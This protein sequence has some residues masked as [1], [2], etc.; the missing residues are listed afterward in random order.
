MGIGFQT[1]VIVPRLD[2]LAGCSVIRS[3]LGE[4]QE[5]KRDLTGET[6]E[7]LKI[8]TYKHACS[9]KASHREM[10]KPV[11]FDDICDMIHLEY[12]P[13]SLMKRIMHM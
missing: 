3:R 12:C 8:D 2:V 7:A 4:T 9:Q 10:Y 13:P 6:G 1:K 11:C 5:E